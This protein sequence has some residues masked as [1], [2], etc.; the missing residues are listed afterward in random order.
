MLTS[1]PWDLR[2][3]QALDRARVGCVVYHSASPCLKIFT[4]VE[5]GTYRA[6]CARAK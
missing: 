3:Q 4:R 6:V 2:D 1:E 5:P